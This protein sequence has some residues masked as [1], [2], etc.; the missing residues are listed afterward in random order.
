MPT[1]LVDIWKE[2]EINQKGTII[3]RSYKSM[4]S[5]DHRLILIIELW[6]NLLIKIHAV[7]SYFHSINSSSSVHPVKC[8]LIV[9]FVGFSSEINTIFSEFM[10]NFRELAPVSSLPSSRYIFIRNNTNIDIFTR[11]FILIHKNVWIRR[12]N[13][14]LLSSVNSYKWESD[15]LNI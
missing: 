12:V 2:W 15:S 14:L 4:F 8:C 10:S 6:V 11:E 9:K 7:S 13:C 3:M 1:G 5:E